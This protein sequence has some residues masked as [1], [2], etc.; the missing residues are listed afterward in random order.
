MSISWDIFLAI[1]KAGNRGSLH[2]HLPH[3]YQQSGLFSKSKKHSFDSLP[4]KYEIISHHFYGEHERE[5]SKCQLSQKQPNQGGKACE[6]EVWEVQSVWLVKP[7]TEVGQGAA[8]LGPIKLLS[9]PCPELQKEWE[10]EDGCLCSSL[11]HFIPEW[12]LC[13][14]MIL[15]YFVI[16]SN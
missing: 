12:S 6:W 11:R 3:H 13:L 5:G 7:N 1:S 4:N 2:S 8:M 9:A 14:D 15:V 16:R 10:T